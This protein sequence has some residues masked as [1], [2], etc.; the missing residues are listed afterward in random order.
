MRGT[1]TRMSDR[2]CLLVK[3]WTHLPVCPE[4]VIPPPEARGVAISERSVVVIMMVSPRPEREPMSKGP[5][6]IVSG[7]SIDSLE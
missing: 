4:H 7:V 1:V 6:E 2:P 5:R 3:V